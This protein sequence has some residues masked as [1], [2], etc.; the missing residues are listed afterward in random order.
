MEKQQKVSNQQLLWADLEAST[1]KSKARRDLPQT[2]PE[3]T[4][5]SA[6]VANSR[7][8]T[9]SFGICSCAI[10]SIILSVLNKSVFFQVRLCTVETA[11]GSR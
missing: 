4:A 11:K 5:I 8:P 1:E 6:E 9:P 3:L 2:W 10:F 7:K